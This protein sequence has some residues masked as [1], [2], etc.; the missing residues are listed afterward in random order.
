MNEEMGLLIQI[1]RIDTRLGKCL[2][3]EAK[4][5]S[6]LDE[7]KK[8]IALLKIK[9]QETQALLDKALKEKKDKETEISDQELFLLKTQSRLKEIKNNKEYQAHLQEIDSQKKK[10]GTVEEAVLL[11]MD[12]V[13]VLKNELALQQKDLEEHEAAMVEKS[14]GIV[15]EIS[16][17]REEKIALEH[18]RKVLSEKLGKKVLEQY[19]YLLLSKKGSAVVG[20]SGNTCQGCYMSLPPQLVA[21]VKRNDKLLTCSHCYRMLY[22]QELYFPKTA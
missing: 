2:E 12:R 6:R 18:E 9:V 11:L 14:K 5:N 17:F 8:V 3:N 15:T 20:V 4:I 13:E 10:R 22:W 16:A 19:A 7:D 1:Q 21:E